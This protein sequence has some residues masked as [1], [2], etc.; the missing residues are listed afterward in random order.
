M[1]G[2]SEFLING[3]YQGAALKGPAAPTGKIILFADTG[4]YL[5]AVDEFGTESSL[6]AVVRS[7]ATLT[8]TS[9]TTLQDV[10]GLF[11]HLNA[12]QAYKF[13]AWLFTTFTTSAGGWK[14]GLAA[15][16]T[17]SVTSMEVWG[18]AMTFTGASALSIATRLSSLTSFG[19]TESTVSVT[20]ARILVEGIIVV[21]AAGVL[22]IQFAQNNSSASPS[23]ALAGSHITITP[24][25]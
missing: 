13:E 14:V 8:K 22:R 21:N 19:V 15:D 4:G 24:V 7:T 10:P 18:G 2:A 23:A 11:I 5:A 3:L 1:P 12:G 17:L 20:G 6:P 25:D 16:A 9:D